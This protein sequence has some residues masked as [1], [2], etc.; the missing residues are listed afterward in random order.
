[1]KNNSSS[2]YV[3]S[4]RSSMR[5]DAEKFNLSPSSVGFYSK[6]YSTCALLPPAK[7][8]RLQHSAQI[9]SHKMEWDLA[10]YL[11]TYTI[12]NHGLSP[13]ENC[14]LALSLCKCEFQRIPPYLTQH[15]NASEDRFWCFL[16][17]KIVFINPKVRAN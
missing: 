6:R 16:K 12:F 7:I 4:W 15:G 1:V 11:K 10:D 9:F 5:K 2:F 17:R 3:L 8:K 14:V 13:A